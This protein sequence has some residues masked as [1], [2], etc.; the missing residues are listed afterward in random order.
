VAVASRVDRELTVAGRAACEAMAPA[1]TVV[2]SP[3]LRL[4]HDAVAGIDDES[5][6]QSDR[7]VAFSPSW[8]SMR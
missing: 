8:K 1:L 2:T 5:L 7:E 6:C 4:A 3:G